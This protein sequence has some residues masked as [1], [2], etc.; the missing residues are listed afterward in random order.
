MAD[1]LS[2]SPIVSV[3]EVSERDK[4]YIIGKAH[5]ITGHD[6]IRTTRKH[7]QLSYNWKNM[8]EDIR[9]HVEHCSVCHT[10]APKMK[11]VPRYYFTLSSARPF[12][13]ISIDT[14]GPIGNSMSFKYCISW[15]QLIIFSMD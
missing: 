11:E 4:L 14:V 6:G 5:V 1:G 2:T 15:S 10:Y 7:I 12:E 8:Q 3:A 9:K 13:T